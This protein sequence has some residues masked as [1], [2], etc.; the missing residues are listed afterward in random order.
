M[1]QRFSFHLFDKLRVWLR[2]YFFGPHAPFADP[3]IGVRHPRG[4]RPVITV[5]D[6]F[7]SPVSVTVDGF[8]SRPALKRNIT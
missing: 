8:T 6:A 7:N 3:L 5:A 1:M 2:R 4:H